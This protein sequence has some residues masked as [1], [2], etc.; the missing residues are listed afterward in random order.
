[1]TRVALFTDPG[2]ATFPSVATVRASLLAAGIDVVLYDRV[3]VEPTDASFKAAAA[4]AT[5]GRFDGYVSVGGGS[6]I[7]TCKAANLYATYP[8]DFM[9]YVNPP[10]G[11]GAVVPGPLKPHIACPTTS[12]TGSE[13]TGIAIFDLLEMGAKTGIVSRR[14]RPSLGIVDPDVLRTLPSVVVASSGFD[15]LS[16]ALES[17]TA[18]PYSRRTRPRTG[19][20]RPSSQGANPF[21]ATSRPSKRCGCSGA[22][23]SAPSRIR[24][25]TKRASR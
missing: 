12:G 6:T 9:A 1:M 4:F 17:Y 11:G 3:E 18:L 19:E 7:D 10:I 15:V 2:L 25:T 21:S 5:D 22:T 20:E 24:R 13:C 16:H 23:W 8:A 14:L